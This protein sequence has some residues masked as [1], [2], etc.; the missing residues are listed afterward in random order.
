MGVRVQM[1]CDV[2]G[3]WTIQLK[4]LT[5]LNLMTI[6]LMTFFICSVMLHIDQSNVTSHFKNWH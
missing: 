5:L 2:M 4:V 3:L 6:A 1:H